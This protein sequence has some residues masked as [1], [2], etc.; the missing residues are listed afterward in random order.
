MPSLVKPTS[1]VIEAFR[2][3]QARREHSYPEIGFSN[4]RTPAGYDLDH[5]RVQ[6]GEGREVFEKACAAIREWI[7]F[8]QPWTEIHPSQAPIEK[9][10]VVAVLV[11]L[12][13]LWWLN[14]CRIVYVID[15][16]RRF[17]FA[18]GTLPGH[19]E[20]GEERF[21]VEWS[22]D[23]TVWYDIRAFSRPRFW[24]ARLGY[25]IS[26]RVQRR[27]VRDSKAAMQAVCGS[28]HPS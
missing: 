7:L 10:T 19:A 24:L 11:H 5:N 15:E 8:P 20:R 3:G 17:G 22:E 1:A 14:A 16:P 21:S 28:I 18:Y 23:G 27:F 9:G 13:G 4:N 2:A 26:R 25:P 12:F 6:L